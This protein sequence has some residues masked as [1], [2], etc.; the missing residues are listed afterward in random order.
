MTKI[1]R[2]EQCPC[3]S[4]KK[5]KHCCLTKNAAASTNP[6]VES[7]SSSQSNTAPAG[8]PDVTACRAEG[9]GP[10]LQSGEGKYDAD[11]YYTFGNNLQAQGKLDAAITSYRKALALR[12]DHADTHNNL[13]L[14]LQSLGDLDSAVESY[15]QALSLRP[16]DGVS[17][18]NLGNVLAAK[19]QRDAAVECYRQ[20]VKLDPGNASAAH[21]I[22]ALTAQDSERPPSQ[23]VEKLF[24]DYAATFDT[25]LTQNLGYKMPSELLALLRQSVTPPA[26][27]WEVLDLGCGTGLSGLELAPHA[28]RLT[29][30]DLSG[31]MLE[32]ARARNIYHRLVQSDLLPMMRGEQASSYDVIIAADVLVYLGTLDEIMSEARRLLRTSGFFLFSVEALEELHREAPAVDSLPL[33]QLNPSGRY[34]HSARYLEKLALANGFSPLAMISLQVRSERGIPITAWAAVWESR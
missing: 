9:H 5:Y 28:R 11:F 10:A 2:N 19:G 15:R 16:D 31:K 22:A 3:G 13:G 20:T 27:E 34:A 32:K 23:Y 12:P 33:Y 1:G 6:G 24:D 26:G 21:L 14:A 17:M 7:V 29:G 4:G 25:H 8:F 18:Y 30:V